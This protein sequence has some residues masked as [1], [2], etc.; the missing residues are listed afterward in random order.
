MS[1]L[2]PVCEREGAVRKKICDDFT[3]KGVTFAIEYECGYCEACGTEWI[4]EDDPFSKAKA[5]Y[6]ELYGKE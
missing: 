1:E 2:C 3:W 4:D 6:E 5:K